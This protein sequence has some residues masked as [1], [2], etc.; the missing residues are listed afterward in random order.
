M[1]EAIEIVEVSPRDG[2]QNEKR[3]LTTTQKL[4]LINYAIQAGFTR[5]EVTSFVNPKKVPQMFDTD[6]LIEGLPKKTNKNLKYIGLVLNERGFER[7]IASKIDIINYVIVATDTFSIKNQGAPTL[8]NITTLK[9]IYSKSYNKP[10]IATTIGASFGCPFEGEVSITQLLKI[11]EKIAKIGLTEICLA[12]TIGVATPIEIKKKIKA[13]KSSFPNL[14][15]RLHLHNTRNTGI[16]N[17][18]A[19]IE[20][21]VTGLESSFGGAGGCPF[22]PRATGNIPTED[23]LYMLDRSGITTGLSLNKS[24]EASNWLERQLQ[25]TLPGL[26]KKTEVFPPQ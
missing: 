22:A 23:L 17:A 24:I 16:A 25:K 8:E 7:A 10:E 13:I 14:K 15:I 21:G 19:G 20:E 2:I 1:T 9:S 3:I 5:I 6:E 12:D 11:V 26:L 4:A 18:W